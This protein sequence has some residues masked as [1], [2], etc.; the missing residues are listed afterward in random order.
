MS[1]NH[2]NENEENNPRRRK[3]RWLKRLFFIGLFLSLLLGIA[4]GPGL[5]FFAEKAIT[6]GLDSAGLKGTFSVEG[7]LFSGLELRGVKLTGGGPIRELQSDYLG[8]DYRLSE[9]IHGKIDGLRGDGLHLWVDI[10]ANQSTESTDETISQPEVVATEETAPAP[11]LDLEK[12]RQMVLPIKLQ[13]THSSVKISRDDLWLWQAQDIS[14]THDSGDEDFHLTLGKFMDMDEKV[15][16]NQDVILTWGHNLTAIKNFPIRTDT[17]LTHVI[18]KWEGTTPKHIE[19]KINWENGD[20][21]VNLDDLKKARIQLTQGEINLEKLGLIIGH[22]GELSGQVTRLQISVADIMAPPTTMQANL[23]ISGKNLRWQERQIQQLTIE[24]SLKES[25]LELNAQLNVANEQASEMKVLTTLASPESI[26]APDW[27]TCWHNLK[28]ELELTIPDP[29]AIAVWSG[30]PHPVGGWPTG[31]LH[32]FAK[33]HM[34]GESPGDASAQIEWKSPQWA[35]LA[36]QQLHLT[37]KWDHEKQMVAVTLNATELASGKV[38]AYG[39]YTIETQHYQGNASITNLDLAKL[40]PILDLFKQDIPRAG[41]V[42][43]SWDGEGHGAD[44]LTYQGKLDTTI[45]GLETEPDGAPPTDITLTANYA[46]GLELQIDKL[47]LNRDKLQLNAAATWK[48]Q[49]LHISQLELHDQD[50]L[51]IAGQAKLPLSRELSDLDSFLKQPGDIDLKFNIKNLPLA[52]IYRLLPQPTDPAVSGKLTVDLTLSGTLLEPSIQLTS[53]ANRIQ[54]LGNDQI[55]ITDVALNLIT[56]EGK[57]SLDG[58][59]KPDGHQ[60]LILKGTMPFELKKWIDAPESLLEEPIDALLD[61][62]TI[63]LAPFAKYLPHIHKLEGTF[64]TTVE[65][66][67]TLGAPTVN[68]KTSLKITRLD[69]IKEAIPDLRHVNIDI[70]F[71]DKQVVIKPSGCLAAG[72][73]YTLQG[74]IDIQDITNPEFDISLTASK[75]LLW[76]DDSMIVRADAT[77]T[78]KGPY[79]KAQIQGD[80]GLVESL[81]YKDIQIIPLGGGTSTSSGPEKADLPSFIIAKKNSEEES[82]IPKPFDQWTLNLRVRTKEDFLIRGNLAKGNI[83]GDIKV[84]G[85]LSDPKPDGK[86]TVKELSASLPFSRLHVKEGSVIFTPDN[87]LDPQLSIKAT[88]KIGSYDVAISL[89]G[90]ASAPKTLMSSNPPL[91]EN[92]I[93]FLLATGSTSEQLADGASATGKAYQLLVDSVIRSSPGRFKSIIN[94]IAELN[95]KV[96]VNIGASDPFTGRKYNSARVEITDRWNFVASIDLDNNTRGLVV[97]TIHFK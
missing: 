84:N 68:G 83:N 23:L 25:H 24:T 73:K 39:E 56:Q 34:D 59:L 18:C 38:T 41:I 67:G 22:E 5:R 47:Q 4:Q 71:T 49:L 26:T 85:T 45:T 11:P 37:G 80:I 93:I 88:S 28:A 92:E 40:R 53:S 32:F 1:E 12:I 3:R 50:A 97:Y 91:P 78:L 14:I 60:A 35:G 43:L 30:S 96:D 55:P 81:F 61:T 82:A 72:G 6:Q 89:Y 51:L 54:A 46:K 15:I 31:A 42:N 9:L 77:L 66:K 79:E 58:T 57:I 20:F 48:D 65:A 86:I 16:E 19:A 8:V 74:K 76:R 10:S 13:V 21:S 7:S 27:A 70:Q 95:E 44:V 52:E 90:L 36:W 29:H 63:K 69:S 33:G 2:T 94:A 64:V 75:S 62:K 17:Q 87:G